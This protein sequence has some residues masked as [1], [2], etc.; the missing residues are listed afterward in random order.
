MGTYITKLSLLKASIVVL[1]GLVGL[2]GFGGGGIAD[3]TGATAASSGPSASHTN[4]PGE[5]NCAACHTS[6]PV[7][8]GPGAVTLSGIPATWS[9]G[10]QFNITVT[11]SQADGVVY[12]YQMTAIDSQGRK[13]GTLSVPTTSPAQSQVITGIVNQL[14]REYAEHTIDGIVPT[15]FGSKSWSV[16]WTAPAQRTGKVDFYV[17]GNASDSNGQTSGDYIYTA[18]KSSSS[19][20]SPF[21]FDGDRKTDLAIYRPAPG[22]WWVNRSS[23]GGTFATQFGVTSDKVVPADYTGDG[24][25]DVA[26]FRPSTGQ[27]FVLRSEDLSFFAV[28]FG[29]STDVPVPADYD[30]DGKADV[31]VFR[32]STNTWFISKS[33]GGTTITGFGI[34]GD[35]PVAADYDGDGKADIAIYR[36]NAA[37]G[38]QWW[39]QRSL[40]G[41][42]FATQ[43]GAPTDKTVPGDYTGDGK[44]D[45]AFFR[46]STGF[47]NILRSEDFSFFAFPFGSSTDVP[48]PGDYDGD[49]KFDAAV[50]RPSNSTWFANRSTAG[51]LIQQFGITGDIPLPNAYVR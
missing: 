42:V 1:T 36:P 23:N 17:A 11:T 41:T 24:K 49:G 38:S 21:D 40:T 30:G 37:G 25:A 3:L 27:W 15:V 31:A 34:S 32:P 45:I 28:P 22:E 19:G 20:V 9:P 47:W 7:D 26:F 12:G 39:I 18:T 44:A 10:Q 50:F 29:T 6:F 46:P 16:L 43:F 33:S 4:A 51:V 2:I 13:A 14:S 8:S 48:S 5:D 35:L